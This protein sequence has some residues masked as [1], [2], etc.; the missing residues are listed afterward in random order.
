MVSFM[1]LAA[2]RRYDEMKFLVGQIK[3]GQR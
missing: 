3:Q 1:H 2:Y